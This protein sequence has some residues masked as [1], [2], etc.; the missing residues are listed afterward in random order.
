MT[1]VVNRL[2][3]VF[4][5]GLD[6]TVKQWEEVISAIGEGDS[7]L[8]KLDIEDIDQ[9]RTDPCLLAKAVTRREEV[10]LLGLDLSLGK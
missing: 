5:W 1:S 8:K 9:S 7:R 6:L 3:K 4:L 10:E 2:E